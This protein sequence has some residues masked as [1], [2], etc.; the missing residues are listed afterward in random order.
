VGGSDEQLAYYGSV[1][2]TPHYLKVFGRYCD[3]KGSKILAQK[4]TRRDGRSVTMLETVRQAAEWV[5]HKIDTSQ[6]GMVEYQRRN[7]RGIANQVWKDSEEFYV[8]VNG[9]RAKHGYKD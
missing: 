2:A 3:S 8:H 4:V 5:L 9:K 1:D 7:P 6:S